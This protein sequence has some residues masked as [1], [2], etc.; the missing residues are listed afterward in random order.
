MYFS[1]ENNAQTALQNW[2]KATKKAE[3][4]NFADTL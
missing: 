3:W 4:E 2:H 1:K